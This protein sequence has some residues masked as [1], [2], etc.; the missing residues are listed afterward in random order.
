MV[1]DI[2]VRFGDQRILGHLHLNKKSK[3]LII[4]CHGYGDT[5]DEPVL[6]RI[7]E[8][9]SK[10]HT[11]YRFTFT[12]RTDPDLKTERDNIETITRYFGKD[13]KNIVLLGASLGGLSTLLSV[14]SIK[15]IKKL[16]LI[17]PFAYFF[18]RVAPKFRRIINSMFIL[19]P[20]VKKFRANINYYFK[21][22]NPRSI[23]IPVLLIV[24]ENDKVVN[25][26][27]GKTLYKDIG[28][29]DK[30]IFLDNDFDHGMNRPEYQEKAVNIINNWLK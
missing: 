7:A 25:S 20:F 21:N 17:N 18:K 4:L 24:A 26:I 23:T 12:D 11:V 6:K 14:N 10:K 28:S 22:F 8:L 16:I 29:K 19:Y 15:G 13:Y 1:K 27:H 2:N 9:L 5:K 3:I 30:Q